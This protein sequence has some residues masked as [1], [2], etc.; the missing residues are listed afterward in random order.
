MTDEAYRIGPSPAIESYLDGKAILDA[1]GAW[2]RRR[3]PSGLRIPR[4]ERGLRRRMCAA[5]D[6]LRRPAPGRDPGN[7]LEE[8][9]KAAPR[10]GRGSAGAR[11]P[12]RGPVAGAAPAR[13]GGD[14]VAGAAEGIRGRRR[15]RHAGG[16]ASGGFRCRPRRSEARVGGRLRRRHDAHR[17][18]RHGARGT[19]RSRSSPTAAATSCTSS[20]ATARPSAGTRR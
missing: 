9:G 3:A 1:G 17:A 2:K 16:G 19:S 15:A 20:S 8:R 12:R 11:L 6:R 5:R 14:R 4:R 7:G 13:G 18:L 10:R